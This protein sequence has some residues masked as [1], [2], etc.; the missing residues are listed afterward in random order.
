MKRKLPYWYFSFADDSGFLGGIFLRCRDMKEGIIMA[1][2]LGINPGGEAV[3]APVPERQQRDVTEEAAGKLLS[4][5]DLDRLFPTWGFKRLGDAR[6]AGL[7]LDERVDTVHE[8]CN[9]KKSL[10]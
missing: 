8:E 3:G 9:E 2:R 4:M 10:T 5:A 1:H 6:D 7:E